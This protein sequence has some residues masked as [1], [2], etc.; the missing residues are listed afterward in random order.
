MKSLILAATIIAVAGIVMTTTSSPVWG[1]QGAV[2]NMTDSTN[3]VSNAPLGHL[4]MIGQFETASI[5]PIN[6][7]YIEVS[8]VSNMTI[9]PPNAAGGTTI[10]ATEKAN[11]TLNILPNGLALTRGQSLIVTAG[12]DGEA[13]QEN[14]TCT[15]V[16]IT[17]ITPAGPEGGTDVVSFNTDST[18]Q[19]AFLDNMTGIMQ[20]K[21]SPAGGTIRTWEWKAGTLPFETC[22]GA[23]TTGNQ[24][25][26]TSALGQGE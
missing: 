3:N 19:L 5:N 9:M 18:G 23:P 25:T 4:L 16:G 8:T 17:H 10:N 13:G 6:E 22:G 14:A 1:N 20:S 21:F 24:T 26:I 12:D 7:T 15:F 2:G 11:A